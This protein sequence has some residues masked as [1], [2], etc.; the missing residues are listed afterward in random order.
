M[1]LNR[2]VAS[3]PRSVLIGLLATALA[4][5]AQNSRRDAEPPASLLAIIRNEPAVQACARPGGGQLANM[6]RGAWL[7]LNAK[8]RTFL[9]EGLPPCLAGN[10]NGTRLLYIQ[11][12]AGWRKILDAIG[13]T[14]EVGANVTN[15]WREIVLWQHDS[16]SRSARHLLGFRGTKYEPVSCNMVQFRDGVT[17]KSL[18]RPQYTGCT[19]EFLEMTPR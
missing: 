4:G 19:Q 10:D 11:S 16:A 3:V 2:F 14:V 13:D 7:D 12:G 17:G 5:V 18:T 8:Q 6:Y 15:G 1:K 9:L